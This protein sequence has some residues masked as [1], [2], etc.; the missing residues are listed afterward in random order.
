MASPS[1]PKQ[2]LTAALQY[3]ARGF[4]VLPLHTPERKGTCSCGKPKCSNVGKHPRTKNGWKD[5]STDPKVIKDWWRRWPRANIGIVTGATTG[6]VV[7]DIDLRHGGEK[8]LEDLVHTYGS[9]PTTWA[10]HTGGG[11]RHIYFKHP[12][13]N[14]RN[15][16]SLLPGLDLRGDGGYIVAPPSRH[17]SGKTYEWELSS[18]LDE[19]ELADMP[20][21]LREKL[22]AP[23]TR[24][25]H[26]QAIS[27]IISEGS[28]ND[29]LCRLAGAM[30]R[31]GMDEQG[32]ADALLAENSRRCQPP[33]PEQEVLQIAH[34]VM[35]YPAGGDNGKPQPSD[36][37]FT[38]WGNAQRLVAHHGSDLRYCYVWDRWLVW[39]GIRWQSDTTGEVERRA[40]DTVKSIYGE[41]AAVEDPQRREEIAKHALRSENVQR[42]KAMIEL[43]KSEP[44]IATGPDELDRA[45]WLLN[46]VNGTIDLRTGELRP[47]RREDLITKLAPVDYDPAAV[48]P[49]W[50]KFL[51]RI[52]N[53][54]ERLIQFLQ[55]SLGYA[56]TGVITEQVVFILHGLGSNGK[57]TFQEIPRVLLGDYAQQAETSTFLMDNRDGPRNDLAALKGARL[58][59]ASEMRSGQRL[60]E[61]LVKQLTGG[62]AVRARF[63]YSESFEF[64]PQFKLFLATNHKPIIRGTDHAI[65]RRIRFIPFMVTI[66]EAEQDK[67]LPEKLFKELPGI[68]RWAVEGCLAW[69][70]HGLGVPEEVRSA[71]E[72]YRNEM[73]VLGDFLADCCVLHPHG[74]AAS[75]TLYETYENWC[76]QNGERPL[77]KNSLGMRLTE[78]GLTQVR[79]GS[80]QNRGWSGI[81]LK[82]PEQ[83]NPGK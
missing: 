22:T 72:K 75:K 49:L 7:L 82:T 3:A 83:S 40:K 68:L 81:G 34:S 39:D 10:C 77:S 58:I 29:S 30:R 65:W 69:Q 24:A 45:P 57:S 79:M 20:G 43:A 4:R 33:L 21:W 1:D 47:H 14:V 74:Q 36:W 50:E 28:R 5:A 48:C 23:R 71:T 46:V 64:Q 61:A 12:G 73:D 44:G 8:S 13:G 54:N 67:R 76:A 41:A 56:L 32:I 18:R 11:G 66:P 70:K 15:K 16:T 59:T 55:R 62:D 53:G 52:M 31:Q 37:H 9:L 80:A 35:R 19:V 60:D 17:A 38:D 27:D 2:L 26:S 42:L 78:R 25:A 51:H 63:L 6:I